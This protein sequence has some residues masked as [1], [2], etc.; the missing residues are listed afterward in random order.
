MK[1]V[2][3][4]LVGLVAAGL[5]GLVLFPA[6]ASA[7]YYYNKVRC[8]SP[9]WGRS[10]LR[11]KPRTCIIGLPIDTAHLAY[12]KRMTWQW[13]E[14]AR[15]VRGHGIRASN[16]GVR[17]PVRVKLY[18]RIFGAGESVFTKARICSRYGCGRMRIWDW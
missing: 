14:Q 16:Q 9:D 4:V 8:I 3:G 1:L 10:V 5:V 13:D 11:A 15:V 18:D 2:H 12:L 17:Y 7:S 6:P